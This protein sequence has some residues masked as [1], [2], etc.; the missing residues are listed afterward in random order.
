VIDDP[1]K[2]SCAEFEKL[3]PELINSDLEATLHPHAQSCERCRRLLAD[4]EIIAEAAG[5]LFPGEAAVII[6][7]KGPLIN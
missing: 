7:G 1:R 6:P 4:L 5:Q 2:M 3:V